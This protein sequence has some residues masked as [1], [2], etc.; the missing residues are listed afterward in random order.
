MIKLV[1]IMKRKEG[2][3]HEEF[4]RHWE[5]VHGPLV[6]KMVPGV[7]RYVQSHAAKL[8]GGGDPPIDG[9]AEVWFDD[10]ASWRESV[11]WHRSDKG[12]VLRDDEDTFLD[13]S[14]MVHFVAEEKVIVE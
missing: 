1:E 5:E 10:I 8:S 9:I 11:K 7:R 14:K 2:L 13:M 12:K 3:T 6:A 4:T